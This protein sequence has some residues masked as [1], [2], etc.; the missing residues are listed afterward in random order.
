MRPPYDPERSIGSLTKEISKLLTRN[1]DARVRDFG[2][3]HTQWQALATLSREQGLK[4]VQLAELLQI[5]PISLAR[6]IDRM[7]AAGWVERRADPADRRALRLFL[8][9]QVDPVLEQMR[10]A[11]L[12][13]RE[14]A[15]AGFAEPE[16]E[17]LF[18][19]LQ[20]MRNNLLDAEAR[21]HAPAPLAAGGDVR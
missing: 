20:R 6:L 16:R 5:Q 11:A 14:D 17:Q 4:Q 21:D 2:L 19:L 18:A 13:L 1:F 10:T 3:T 12:A 9:P 7:E 8:T 15:L